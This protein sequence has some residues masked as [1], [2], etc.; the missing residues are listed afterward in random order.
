ME[1]SQQPP[2]GWDSPTPKTQAPPPGWDQGQRVAQPPAGWDQAP[3]AQQEP[4]QQPQENLLQQFAHSPVGHGIVKLGLTGQRAAV[5]TVRDDL[6]GAMNIV[7]TPARVAAGLEHEGGILTSPLAALGR[8]FYNLVDIDAGNKDIEDVSQGIKKFMPH[9]DNHL[10]DAF[11]HFGAQMIQDPTTILPF[12][13]AGAKTIAATQ[14]AKEIAAGVSSVG[15]KIPGLAR[16]ARVGDKASEAYRATIGEFARKHFTGRE[17]LDQDLTKGGKTLRLGIEARNAT[18]MQDELGHSDRHLLKSVDKELANRKPGE[19][20]PEALRQRTLQEA[21]RYGDQRARDEAVELGYKPTAADKPWEQSPE[22]LIEYPHGLRKDYEYTGDIK[23]K[24]NDLPA[25]SAMKARYGAKKASF[26]YERKAHALENLE[27]DQRKRWEIRLRLGRDMVMKRRIDRETE[28]FLT[29]YG[30]WKGSDEIEKKVQDALDAHQHAIANLKK[31]AALFR[32]NPGVAANNAISAMERRLKELRYSKDQK[33][34][35]AAADL[36]D[37]IKSIKSRKPEQH[38][39]YF[40]KKAAQ[41]E[42]QAKKLAESPPD[43]NAVVADI[44]KQHIHDLVGRLTHTPYVAWK[45]YN[46]R[47]LSKLGKDSIIGTFLPHLIGN[48]GTFAAWRGGIPVLINGVRHALPLAHGKALGMFQTGIP[49][50]MI[51]RMKNIGAYHEFDQ[52]FEKM[53]LTKVPGAKQLLQG[54]NAILNRGELAL[55]AAILE[56]LDKEM[57]PS[58]N[59]YDEMMKSQIVR[60]TAGDTRN[61]SA[62]VSLLEAMGAPF[63]GFAGAVVHNVGKTLASPNAYRVIAPIRAQ[64]DMDKDKQDFHGLQMMNPAITAAHLL[65][66]GALS[67]SHSGPIPSLIGEFYSAIHG[68]PSFKNPIGQ[69]AEAVQQYGGPI[70]SQLPSLFGVPYHEQGKKAGDPDPEEA[71]LHFLTGWFHNEHAGQHFG[72]RRINRSEARAEDL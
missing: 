1:R 7:T 37:K 31:D 17:E 65:G 19:A 43:K 14:L 25:F 59:V 64:Q 10:L 26:E 72:D 56:S 16:A 41:K 60:E 21:W 44:T 4:A 53:F 70:A 50:E 27:N 39:A 57:G 8:A 61:V 15:A 71:L 46:L 51:G 55:R 40:A 32:T 52:D 63:A 24:I 35:E 5:D 20:V 45:D 58:K 68:H 47:W 33:D 11:E 67:E 54:S 38:A 48:L 66:S 18:K 9:T 12:A 13:F 30:G 36:E 28:H 42:D 29:K 69:A 23:K 6:S 2:P 34:I 22:G 49:E 3:A 62:F